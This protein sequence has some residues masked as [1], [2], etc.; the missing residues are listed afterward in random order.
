MQD[1]NHPASAGELLWIV[2]IAGIPSLACLVHLW[3]RRDAGFMRKSLWTFAVA[4]PI[5][6]PL[7]YGSRFRAPEMDPSHGPSH[8]G[9]FPPASV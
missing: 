4:V 6:G 9:S 5:I 8:K 7:F 3:L 2:V 1:Q